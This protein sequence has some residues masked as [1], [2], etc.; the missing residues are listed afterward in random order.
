MKD[1]CGT[2][3]M[4]QRIGRPVESQTEDVSGPKSTVKVL[5]CALFF[6]KVYVVQR[7]AMS[8]R[9]ALVGAVDAKLRQRGEVQR[10]PDVVFGR[11]HFLKFLRQQSCRPLVYRKDIRC[12]K[13][14]L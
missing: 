5:H 13:K 12:T 8:H 9:P 10:A 14:E 7:V 6:C 11:P 2:Y 3:Q 4:Q 1:R